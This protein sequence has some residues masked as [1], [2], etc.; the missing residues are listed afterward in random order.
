[1]LQ[2]LVGARVGQVD[3]VQLL[4]SYGADIDSQDRG[5]MSCLMFNDNDIICKSK[6]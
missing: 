1:M 3:V 6:Q 2:S 4:Y 5:K